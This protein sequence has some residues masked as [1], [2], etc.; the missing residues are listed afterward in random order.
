MV[1]LLFPF[2]TKMKCAF[3]V[4]F[5]LVL[6]PGINPL[7]NWIRKNVV[8]MICV[9]RMMVCRKKKATRKKLFKFFYFNQAHN[10]KA[11]KKCEQHKREKMNGN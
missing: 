3:T 11:L 4:R 7:L 10:R 5:W 8:R 6:V 9:R 1:E 2:L